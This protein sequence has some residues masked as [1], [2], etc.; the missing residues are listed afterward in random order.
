MFA[1]FSSCILRGR[2]PKK[3]PCHTNTDST[4]KGMMLETSWN[5]QYSVSCFTGVFLPLH[6]FIRQPFDHRSWIFS[7]RLRRLHRPQ[8][9][10]PTPDTVSK[11]TRDPHGVG[12][13]STSTFGSTWL[14]L[15]HISRKNGPQEKPMVLACFWP[16]SPSNMT[17][18][19]YFS[20]GWIT[21]LPFL[22]RKLWLPRWPWVGPTP[23]PSAPYI[24]PSTAPLRLERPRSFSWIHRSLLSLHH[25]SPIKTRQVKLLHHAFKSQFVSPNC[26][27]NYSEHGSWAKIWPW[28]WDHRVLY[29][30]IWF[31]AQAQCPGSNSS[32]HGSPWAP[33]L[34]LSSQLLILLLQSFDDFTKSLQLL[35]ISLGTSLKVA[36]G[37]LPPKLV[38]SW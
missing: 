21:I 34:E 25:L 19:T 14:R 35:L 22:R 5:C 31:H 27:M 6:F 37:T 2:H 15:I 26:L 11:V 10:R 1:I 16:H 29:G 33:C 8:L 18:L 32:P 24:W 20:L 4:E 23:S 3:N 38:K 13:R 28:S 12:G 36:S 7:F 9:L 30:S 17:I